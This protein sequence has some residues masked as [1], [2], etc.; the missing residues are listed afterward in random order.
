MLTGRRG[1]GRPWW[2]ASD[3]APRPRTLRRTPHV[4]LIVRREEA[5][6]VWE[7]IGRACGVAAIFRDVVVRATPKVKTVRRV[8]PGA[9]DGAWLPLATRE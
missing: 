2:W 4:E 6:P 7:M 8:A 5:E 9:R 3:S 1:L